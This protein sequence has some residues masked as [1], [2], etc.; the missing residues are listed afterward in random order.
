VHDLAIDRNGIHRDSDGAYVKGGT[1]F[2]VS[3]MLTGDAAVGWITRTYN[4][5][6][7]K[8]INGVTFDAS[9]LWLM[10]GLTTVKLTARTTVDES[11]V[12]GV[13]GVF[14][15]EVALQIDHAF[16][17]WLI[18]TMRFARAS[19]E[20]VGS[21]RDDNR[22]ALSLGLTYKLTRELALKAE[23]RRDWLVSS[24]PGNDYTSNSVLLGA[25]LQR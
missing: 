21:L 9:L 4:D 20:Y 2:E 5:P 16:R 10:S 11:T 23:V 18:A 24:L 8:D 7:L 14:T 22:Y 25:R 1:T 17:R 12:V 15:R 13:S 6:K 19:D 3:R